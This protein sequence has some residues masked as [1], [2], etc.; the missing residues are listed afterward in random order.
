MVMPEKMF[1]DKERA[2][3]DNMY[4]AEK[5][6]NFSSF[7]YQKEIDWSAKKLLI[8][9]GRRTG[10]DTVVVNNR[11]IPFMWTWWC[12]V[13]KKVIQRPK[14]GVFAP[15]WEE[16]DAFM[17]TFR[18]AIEG[19]V[20]SKSVVVDN[21]F[22]VQLSNGARLM[23]R[24]ASKSSTG[25]RG[26]GFDLL[27]YTEAAFISDY[28]MAETS[29]TRLIG[30][31]PEIQTSAPF[32]D[33]NHFARAEDSGIYKFYHWKTSQSPL[34]SAEDLEDEKKMRT[35]IEYLL[36]YDAERIS[37]VGQAIPDKLIQKAFFGEKNE[38]KF[39]E[40]GE[41]GKYY[42]AGVDLGRRRDK[43]TIYVLKIE[44]PHMF[45]VYYKEHDLNKEDP[46]FWI[47]VLE[48]AM[49]TVELFHVSRIRVDQTGIGDMPVVELKRVFAEKNISCVVDGVDF[50]YAL[51]HKWEGLI[52]Q[53]ILKFERYEIH[54][55][56]IIK[57]VAQLKSIRFNATTK[58][59]EVRGKS[60][61]Q[62][63][64]L[65][66][67]MSAVTQ[68]KHYFGIAANWADPE[69]N[70]FAV[71]KIIEKSEGYALKASEAGGNPEAPGITKSFPWMK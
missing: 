25:K 69:R 23:C 33:E 39:E 57:L 13:R 52:N 63:M 19:S 4:F 16:A 6:L 32:N 8:R 2:R 56:L 22:D 38:L 7:D 70:L 3:H 21:K 50:T 15:G 34:V 49:Y 45:I 17:D 47:K 53:A 37:G 67:A 40:K 18:M 64:A 5:L 24:I 12:P 46:R 58:M 43:S 11:I 54:G 62:V 68:A 71:D 42:V 36:L 35:E 27:Y 41:P 51:K 48:H 61:D 55:P 31:A 60:P 66:L 10:K 44:W 28:D 29:P 1:L 9:G 59:Y 14:V 26:R 65:F 20:L 30:S